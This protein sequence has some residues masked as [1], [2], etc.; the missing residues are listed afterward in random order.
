MPIAAGG[1]AFGSFRLQCLRLPDADLA[2][3]EVNGDGLPDLYAVTSTGTL[4][5]FPGTETGGFGPAQ[6]TATSGIDWNQIT[7]IA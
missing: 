6:P 4:E 1:D 3:R 7:A 5:L 2:R